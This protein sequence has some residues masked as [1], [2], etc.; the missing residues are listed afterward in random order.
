MQALS[1]ALQRLSSLRKGARERGLPGGHSVQ[2]DDLFEHKW[3]AVWMKFMLW[4]F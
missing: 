4:N 3:Q 1:I 2:P